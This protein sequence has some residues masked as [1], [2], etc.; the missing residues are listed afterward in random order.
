ME[1]T[2]D[3]VESFRL[4]QISPGKAVRLRKF[5]QS[6][7]SAS[8]RRSYNFGTKSTDRDQEATTGRLATGVIG[9]LV[10]EIGSDYR[11]LAIGLLAG[12]H[13][14]SPLDRVTV[15]RIDGKARIDVTYEP[16]LRTV[17]HFRGAASALGRWTVQLPCTEIQINDR[18]NGVLVRGYRAHV[19]GVTRV[20][21]IIT[22]Q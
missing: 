10:M 14:I 20:T 19:S 18:V 2:V 22:L 15:S 7:A 9:H 6:T 4:R 17:R 3:P 8:F 5:R 16:G 1:I 12:D 11:L 21:V 13:A